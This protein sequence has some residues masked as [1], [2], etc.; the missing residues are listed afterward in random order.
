[1]HIREAVPSFAVMAISMAGTT[2][3]GC[4]PVINIGGANF[5]GWLVCA[6]AGIALAAIIRLLFVAV[7]IE[8]YLGPAV[9]IYPCLV[10]LLACL[11]WLIFFNRI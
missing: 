4:D 8:T 5:P 3:G 10:V 7:G 11:T 2:I 1:M 9:L 6:I